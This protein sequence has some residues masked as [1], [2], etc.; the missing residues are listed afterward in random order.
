MDIDKTIL[1]DDVIPPHWECPHCG[2]I[3]ETD[4]CA[5]D[6]LIE[7]LRVLRHCGDCGYVH[8]WELR[9]TE[10][11]KQKVVELLLDGAK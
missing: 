10:K 8:C 2:A 4:E 1:T 5:N 9:L 7:H 11:F 3:N 6:I